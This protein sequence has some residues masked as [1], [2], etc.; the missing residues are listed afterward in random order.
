M[1]QVRNL[2]RDG[3]GV[4][5]NCELREDALEVRGG[6]K[7][8]QVFDGVIGNHS[9]AVQD[10]DARRDLLHSLKLMRTEQDHLAASGKHLD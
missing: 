7:R 6:H 1:D 2:V 10:D 9:A 4:L 3:H 8:T 5:L